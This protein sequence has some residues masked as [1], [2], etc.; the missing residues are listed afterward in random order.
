MNFG[1]QKRINFLVCFLLL[2]IA[3]LNAQTA[4][5]K[6]NSGTVNSLRSI[7]FYDYTTGF[8]VGGSGTVLK[9]TDGGL[10]WQ[11]ITIPVSNNLNDLYI[12]N[13]STVVVVGDS[14]TI[15]FSIDG[16]ANW[17]VGPY[18]TT[19]EYFSVS[20]S[21]NYGIIGGSSQTILRAEYSGTAITFYEIQSGF[22]GGGFY[23]AS[24]LSDQIGFI[25]GENSIF[26]PL[27]GKTTDSG[28]NWDFTSFYL[29]GNEGKATGVDFTD[30]NT[31]YIS[32]AVWDGTGAISKTINSGTSWV[33]TFNA[34]PLWS[35]DFPI[36]GISQVGYVV[37]GSGT[38]LKTNDAGSNW[39]S[40]QSGTMQT[41]NKVFFLDLDFG[42]VVGDS[43]I[44]LRTINGGIPVELISFTANV[45]D[46]NVKL[47]WTTVTET[48]N[49]GFDI[50]R[51]VGNGEFG[52]IGFV[53]GNGT[54]TESHSYIFKDKNVKAGKYSYRLKQIDYD[55][56]FEYS[57]EVSLGVVAPFKFALDQNF[58]NPFNP[59]TSIQYAVSSRQYV[60][61]KVYDI[62]G[63][64][65]A[66]L[67]NKEK[68]PGK[69]EIE[70]DASSL[71]SGIYFYQLKAGSFVET[72]KMILLK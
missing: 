70:F 25:A 20:F 23:G 34:N 9:S 52:N 38:I 72:R 13:D 68:P 32:A 41:L 18:L 60:T 5:T 27:L 11:V 69:Y 49:L 2:L 36:S 61:L 55:G 39:Q 4:W 53:S 56:D 28:A 14:G 17:F 46:R 15:I 64:E 29:D 12:F 67:V 43:G 47:A 45:D 3:D 58:P 63:N 35:I 22:F 7:Y 26:Q 40:Q 62:L 65:V 51:K 48:N 30:E 71:P 6:M 1:I 37:G 50:E 16:G 21:G 66:T 42:F 24:M 54:S 8:A 10:S 44:V 59:G 33:T 57:N 19:E 31:G